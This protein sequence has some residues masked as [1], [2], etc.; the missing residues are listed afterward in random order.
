MKSRPTIK[1]VAMEV[2]VSPT[3]V[4]YVMNQN[5]D[6]KISEATRK[7]IL[8]AAERLQYVP[9]GAARSLRY[10]SSHCISVALEKS[11]T[12]TRFGSFLQGIRDGLQEEGYWLMLFDQNSSGASFYPDYLD[13]VLQ[14]RA[15]GII[16]ISSDGGWPDDQWRKMILANNLPFVACDCCPPESALASVSFDYERG[17][18]ELGCYL[19]GEGANR[20]LYW[21]P[22]VPTAQELYREA[23]LRRAIERFP[24]AEFTVVQLP[25]EEAENSVHET[26]YAT[27]SRICKQ[28]MMEDVVPIIAGFAPHDA[29]ICSWAIMVKHLSS[30]LNG[31]NRHIKIASL[32]DAEMPVLPEPRILVSRPGFREGGKACA[33]LILRQVRGEKIEQNRILIEPAT[34]QYVEF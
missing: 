20:L 34:P 19:L 28:H 13:S 22:S 30:L 32:S 8:E 1:D 6:H 18:F 24:H 14:R 7:A 17:A 23:G 27:F 25:Y 10:N 2:G 4:S 11:V 31:S 16:Y 15:D 3:T 12:L 5:K 9:N 33:K 21:R 29:V 26:R